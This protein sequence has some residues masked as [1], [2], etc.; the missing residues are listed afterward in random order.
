MSV[1]EVFSYASFVVIFT[2]AHELWLAGG[3]CRRVVRIY[4]RVLSLLCLAS[5]LSITNLTARPYVTTPL[6]FLVVILIPLLRRRSV[7]NVP[8][9]DFSAAGL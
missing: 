3:Q 4:I 6:A 8:E 7:V 5:T 9:H 2:A 1:A